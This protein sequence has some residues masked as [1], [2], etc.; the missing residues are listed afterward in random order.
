MKG[1]PTAIGTG[2]AGAATGIGMERAG[3]GTTSGDEEDDAC[4]VDG[5]VDGGEDGADG[6][7]ER[8]VSWK[9]CISLA[10]EAMTTSWFL[11]L[12][13]M[14][15]TWSARLVTLLSTRVSVLLSFSSGLS[16]EGADA[17]VA[18]GASEASSD[19]AGAG[20][21]V[22]CARKGA[23][24]WTAAELCVATGLRIAAWLSIGAAGVEGAITGAGTGAGTGAVGAT[25]GADTDGAGAMAGAEVWITA[26]LSLA[27]P[28]K[29]QVRSGPPQF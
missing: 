22:A 1:A 10:N 9:R 3:G 8:M 12:V 24:L 29:V 13:S 26:G 2:A 7:S 18:G 21:S 17:S 27:K 11:F 5:G 25:S 20:A 6:R 15:L 23:G 4:E 19:A 14:T 28:A 16:V